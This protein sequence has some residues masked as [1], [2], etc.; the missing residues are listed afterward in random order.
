MSGSL[1][2]PSASLLK[3]TRER[4]VHGGVVVA[5][6]DA[7][8]VVAPVVGLQWPFRAENHAGCHGRLATGV[9]DVEAFQPARLLIHIQRFGQCLEPCSQMLTARQSRAERLFGVG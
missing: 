2:S 4:L 3:A 7:F 9:A 6:G 5:R 8:D 1:P